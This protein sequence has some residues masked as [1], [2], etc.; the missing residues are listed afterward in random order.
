[1]TRRTDFG[2]T[3]RIYARAGIA[4]Y[5]IVNLADRRIEVYTTPSGPGAA[6]DYAERR[7]YGAEEAVPVVV[8]GREVGRIAVGDVLPKG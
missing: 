6:P 7:D 1:M 8:D 5:W 4:V 2:H 3:R